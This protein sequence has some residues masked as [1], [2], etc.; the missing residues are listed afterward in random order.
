MEYV[1]VFSKSVLSLCSFVGSAG[2]P[3]ADI[4]LLSRDRSRLNSAQYMLLKFMSSIVSVPS[5][6]AYLLFT[7]W[8]QLNPVSFPPFDICLRL[9]R[10][11]P[12][13]DK[14]F[15]SCK[16]MQGELFRLPPT[17]IGRIARSFLV[18]LSEQACLSVALK[19]VFL[20]CIFVNAALVFCTIRYFHAYVSF[21]SFG[22]YRCL[23]HVLCPFHCVRFL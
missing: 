9:L 1:G 22:K 16:H 6:I 3:P 12:K 21:L 11:S 19:A 4:T 10:I 20:C 8:L 13:V 2:L 15:I 5:K 23:L 14:T 18:T 17:V 7:W